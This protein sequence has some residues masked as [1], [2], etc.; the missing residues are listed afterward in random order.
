MD[1]EEEC[2]TILNG[3]LRKEMEY[4]VETFYTSGFHPVCTDIH[5]YFLGASGWTAGSSLNFGSF[6]PISDQIYSGPWLEFGIDEPYD[7]R[8][9][10]VQSTNSDLQSE[11]D[12]FFTIF[13][14][15]AFVLARTLSA[16]N[17]RALLGPSYAI[18][19]FCILGASIS[20]FLH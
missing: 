11:N 10:I 1:H 18:A 6:D 15:F 13:S 14:R 7:N 5:K 3:L 9:H 20:S 12:S 19:P 4:M 2:L 8:L 16:A 17:E